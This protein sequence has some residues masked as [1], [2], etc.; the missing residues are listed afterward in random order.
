M[1][2]RSW[3]TPP[4][5]IVLVVALIGAVMLV[6]TTGV[7]SVAVVGMWRGGCDPVTIPG[8]LSSLAFAGM[9]GLAGLLAPGHQLYSWRGSQQQHAATMAGEAAAHAVLEHDG[10]QELRRIAED[11]STEQEQDR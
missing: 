4:P 1:A 8:G 5:P 3:H 11:M 2:E 7:V 9:T 6:A 10:V